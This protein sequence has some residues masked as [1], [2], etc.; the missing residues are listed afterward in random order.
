MKSIGVKRHKR[1]RYACGRCRARKQRCDGDGR[2]KCSKCERA[3]VECIVPELHA[4]QYSKILEEKV[5]ILEERI[6]E[7]TSNKESKNING[8]TS[9]SDNQESQNTLNGNSSALKKQEKEEHKNKKRLTRNNIEAN[10]DKN[11]SMEGALIKCA[12]FISLGSETE[13][14]YL[15]SSSGLPLAS[16]VQR[17][18]WDQGIPEFRNERDDNLSCVTSSVK[19]H[20]T[21]LPSEELSLKLVKTYINKVHNRFSFMETKELLDIH[22]NYVTNISDQSMDT[23]TTHI[24]RFFLLMVYAIG[25]R[26]LQMVGDEDSTNLSADAFYNAAMESFPYVLGIRDHKSIQCT[27]LIVVYS[28]RSRSPAGPGVWHVVGLAMR[29]CIELGMHRNMVCKSPCDA[30][31]VQLRRRIFWTV[32]FLERTISIALGRPYSI[33]ERDIDTDLPLD[34]D[35]NRT[36]S[37]ALFSYMNDNSLIPKEY[38]D[39]SL[40]VHLIKLRRIDSVIQ[41]AIYRVDRDTLPSLQEVDQLL[42]L[43][44]GWKNSTPPFPSSREQN[45]ISLLYN[46]S[47]RFLLVPFLSDLSAD[48]VLCK[49]CLQASGTICRVSKTLHQEGTYAHSF[50][51]IQTLFMA[52]L[53]IIYGLWTGKHKWNYRISDELNSCSTVLFVV[54]DKSSEAKQYRDVFENLLAKTTQHL[55]EVD[56]ND[57][58]TPN[59]VSSVSSLHHL[60]SNTRGVEDPPLLANP[61]TSSNLMAEDMQLNRQWD[62]VGID[63]LWQMVYDTSHPNYS[64]TSDFDF[65]SLINENCL[66]L[67]D[68]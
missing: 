35:E 64:G 37:D 26:F 30:L 54:A 9:I 20:P 47:V 68:F 31:Y 45:Y 19:L 32:Y 18:V 27:M 15:G 1:A 55:M 21:N 38:T 23:R 24:N 61:I 10:E 50:I 4:E 3:G 29:M 33:S 58:T 43:I 16:V 12:A 28:L 63:D 14:S 40:G 52:G 17:T 13:P 51:A 59:S 39:L 44:N 49:T 42:D 11:S 46:K 65:S 57:N 41:Q 67:A 34:V 36:D 5:R 8:D 6:S 66:D 56:E 48:H 53:T 7:L 22:E 60:E 62:K 2:E 25:V